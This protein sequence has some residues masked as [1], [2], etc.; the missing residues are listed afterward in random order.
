MSEQRDLATLLDGSIE[1][2]PSS[3]PS[4]FVGLIGAKVQELIESTTPEEL[5]A[6]KRENEAR[7]AAYIA[8]HPAHLCD[9]QEYDIRWYPEYGEWL[10]DGCRDEVAIHFCPFCGVKLEAPGDE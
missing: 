9:S 8:M 2:V 5:A 1:W 7:V 4:A 6:I 3:T 10:L